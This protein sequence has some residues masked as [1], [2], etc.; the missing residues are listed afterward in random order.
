MSECPCGFFGFRGSGLR[1]VGL[2]LRFLELK[3]QALGTPVSKFTSE[4]FPPTWP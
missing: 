4:R 2:E 1:G 3:V